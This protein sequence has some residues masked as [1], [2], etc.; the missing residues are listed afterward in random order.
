[1]TRKD[2][3]LIA[4]ALKY[5]RDAAVSRGRGGATVKIK[6]LDVSGLVKPDSF[7]PDPR[8]ECSHGIHFFMT[9]KEAEAY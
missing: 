8:V 1:M 6:F 2:Y 5:A 7:D 4:A 3:I 9:R